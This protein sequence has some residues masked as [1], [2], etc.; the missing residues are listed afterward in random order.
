M[1]TL[2]AVMPSAMIAVCVV[3]VAILIIDFAVNFRWGE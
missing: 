3:I 1:N 2:L